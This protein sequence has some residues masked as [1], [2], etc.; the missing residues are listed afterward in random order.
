[1]A[2]LKPRARKL[3]WGVLLAA[4]FMWL[5]AMNAQHAG[6]TGL[7][8]REAQRRNDAVVEAM[9]LLRKGDEAY[10][11]TDYASA[12]EA[13][14]G[15]REMIPNV[16]ASAELH[17]AVTERLVTAS[18][19]H[20]RALSR[21]GDIR[22]A[23][24]AVERVLQQDIAPNH[25]AAA[26]MLADLNDPI[27]T[28]PAL[29]KEHAADVD[30]V[31]RT[32]YLAEGAYN[33]GK[34]DEANRHYERVLQIDP[35]NR[36][37]RRGME[38]IVQRKV[39]Y[40]RAAYDHT[41]AEM[42]GQVDAQWETQ[43]PLVDEL[44]ELEA[45]NFRRFEDQ[46]LQTLNEKIKR[47]I[48][49]SFR[50]EQSNLQEAV[51]LLRVRARDHDTFET[52]ALRRGVNINVI[53]GE[54]ADEILSRRI[55]LELSNITIEGILQY[56]CDQ[57]GTN[58]T[59]DGHSIIIRPRSSHQDPMVTR[60]FRVPPDFLSNLSGAVPTNNEPVDIFAPPSNAGLLPQRLGIREALEANGIPFVEG[61]RAG[62]SNNVLQVTHTPAALELI[63]QLV[64]TISETEPISVITRVTILR[65]QETMLTE[66]GFDWL[67][68]SFKLGGGGGEYVGIGGGTQSGG[69]NLSDLDPILIDPTMGPITAGNRSGSQAIN[70]N[71][72]LSGVARSDDLS[73]FSTPRAPGILSVS[74]V[75]NN[76]TAQMV[77]R[78]LDQKGG[79]DIMNQPSLVTR[80]GQASSIRVLR[81]FIYPTEYDPPEIPQSVGN[82]TGG[83]VPITPANPTAFGMRETGLVLEVLPLADATRSYVDVTIAPVIT[84]FD[85]F[86]NYGTP[87]N[88]TFINP[89]TG[90]TETTELTP[91]AILQPIF[92]VSRVNTQVTVAD[93]AT[94]VLGGL[95]QSRIEDVQ[96]QTPILGGIPVVGRFFQTKSRQ[97]VR[98][99]VIFFVNVELIDPTGRPFRDR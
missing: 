35:H 82:D 62:L 68:G 17:H 19:E 13:F 66:L 2:I 28:N 55:N 14:A 9:E 46:Q 12:V 65:V 1:M 29:T 38:R 7:A 44:P 78:G 24:A 60:N 81:E 22:G 33:L 91:N 90:L 84:N 23:K 11:D 57:T 18:V 31:R 79:V 41:R 87:I 80:N 56:L 54:N 83:S 50:I 98:T 73:S 8:Q 32:L 64:N 49:P 10:L 96:D 45:G 51:E 48:I 76:T 30:Q 42:L 52:E 43:L 74:G 71:V 3:R 85:G 20:A 89:I 69:G 6:T 37:A 59:T 27:R 21:Q 40:Q 88:S 58:F 72:F 63:E 77:L 99:A 75:M 15:A 39:D 92:S 61:A 67:L 4:A 25:P 53:A 16:P 93:G 36:T 94:V 26:R 5:P 47:I 70:P 86:I 95:L 34:F 97:P